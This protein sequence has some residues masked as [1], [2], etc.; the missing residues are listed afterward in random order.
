MGF[1][2]GGKSSAERRASVTRY[3]EAVIVNDYPRSKAH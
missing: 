2:S 3:F 1:W